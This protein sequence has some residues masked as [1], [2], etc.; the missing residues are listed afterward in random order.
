MTSSPAPQPAEVATPHHHWRMFRSPR[1]RPLVV[2]GV[3]SIATAVVAVIDPNIPGRYPIC[4]FLA[5]TGWYCPGCGSL[6]AVHALTEGEVVAA[7]S[8]N[9]V[10]VIGVAFAM[11]WWLRWMSAAFADKPLPRVIPVAVSSASIRRGKA[12]VM[13][14]I[15]L[16]LLIFFWVLRNMPGFNF[17]AP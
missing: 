4:P 11:V 3:G 1:L 14:S 10:T 5:V 9:P 17:L 2:G 6:R 7:L 12:I 8:S 15:S 13:G 16:G